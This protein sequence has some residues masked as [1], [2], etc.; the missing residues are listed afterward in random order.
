MKTPAAHRIVGGSVAI[1]RLYDVAYAIDLDAVGP[2]LGKVPTRLRLARARHRSIAYSEP[3]VD[4]DLA[5]ADLPVGGEH[6]EVRASARFFEFGAIRL[7]Y[8]MDFGDGDF[9]SLVNRVDELEVLFHAEEPWRGE[10]SRLVDVL[11]P[12]LTKPT[13]SGIEID[14][15]FVSARGFEPWLR[16]EEVLERID[17]VPLITG[18]GEALSRTARAN[19]LGRAMTYYH[20]DLV[21]IGA[22]RSFIVEP[23]SEPDVADVLGMAHAQLLELRYYDQLLAQELIA[24]HDRIGRT[25]RGMGPMARRRYAALARSLYALHAE[26]ASVSERIDNALV[27]TDDV[28]LARVYESALEQHRVPSWSAG[29]HRSLELVRDAYS[30]LND[31]ATSARA[32][33]LEIAIVLLIL[34]DIVLVLLGK[35]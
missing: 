6:V 5:A 26:I 28:Y 25:R 14:H 27:V 11:E 7:S 4:I 23:D 13:S 3:P 19:V 17:L 33:Y 8:S 21:V 32:E 12:A 15:T 22:T 30:A 29:I 2:T 10:L 16:S 9:E 1:T 18:E 35:M 34:I 20:D 24:L 31:E